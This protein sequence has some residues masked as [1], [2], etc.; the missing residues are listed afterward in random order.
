M[1]PWAKKSMVLWELVSKFKES[2]L[3]CSFMKITIGKSLHC[4]IV[5]K[6]PLVWPISY[7][8][9]RNSNVGG[10]LRDCALEINGLWEIK[11]FPGHTYPLE[12]FIVLMCLN[13]DIIEYCSHYENPLLQVWTVLEGTALHASRVKNCG[14]DYFKPLAS[15]IDSTLKNVTWTLSFL[16]QSTG[17]G[18]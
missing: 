18:F 9:M 16:S 11:A 4:L 1:Q 12:F 17:P 15:D 6:S 2:A 3:K 8:T 13:H 5:W 7:R 10:R 14:F